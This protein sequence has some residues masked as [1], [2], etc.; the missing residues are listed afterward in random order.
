MKNTTPLHAD[1][2]LDQ[3]AGQFAHWRQTRPH[4]YGRIPQ[5][6]WDQA[7]A[8]AAT[9]PPSRVAKQLRLCL[10]DLKKQMGLRPAAPTA[11]AARPLG[12][13]EVPP[14]APWPQ[15]APTTQIELHRADGTRLCIYGAA[16]TLPLAVLVQ[17]FLEG[18]SCCN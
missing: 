17:A 1:H 13:V 4:P 14:A 18:R 10:A 5:P 16:S 2:E 15:T 8:V 9:L 3:L 11:V 7:V 6:L 12:F